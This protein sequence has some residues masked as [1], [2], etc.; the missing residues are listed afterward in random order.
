MGIYTLAR[1][2][3]AHLRA[4]ALNAW[5]RSVGWITYASVIPR[6]DTMCPDNAG[7][8]YVAV[9]SGIERRQAT[10]AARESTTRLV[11]RLFAR[12]TTE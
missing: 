7:D 1:V 3:N 9:I 11:G 4:G 5:A 6:P 2:K 8:Q 10:N 12:G